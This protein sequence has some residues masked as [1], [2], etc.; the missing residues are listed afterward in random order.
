MS[1]LLNPEL[2]RVLDTIADD[3]TDDEARIARVRADRA[4]D[5]PWPSPAELAELLAD[6][7]L[8]VSHDAGRLLYALA[9]SRPDG[10]VVELGTSF[11]ASTLHLAAAIADGGGS[12][13]VI[14]TELHPAKA[15]RAEANL[16]AAGVGHVAEVRVGDALETLDDPALGDVSL[17]VLDGWKELYLPV[18]RLLEPRLG[19]GALVVA[20]DTRLFA[21]QLVHYLD[22][23]RH[24]A[25]G[26][27]S[28]DLGVDD[29]LELSV[30]LG[31]VEG[32]S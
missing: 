4:P 12:G 16:E 2:T 6:A 26:W 8:P 27:V 31:A 22:H 14:T 23:V 21:D 10:L 1:L 7:A 5:A 24:P 18:L 15:A 30:R 13:R 11:G 9:R 29:G 32:R 25:N 20:D 3:A 17:V 19:A 28:V